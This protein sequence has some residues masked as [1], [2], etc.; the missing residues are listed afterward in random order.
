MFFVLWFL[1]RNHGSKLWGL[2]YVFNLKNERIVII[3]KNTRICVSFAFWIMMGL[4]FIKWLWNGMCACILALNSMWSIFKLAFEH[5]FYFLMGS[6]LGYCNGNIE[7]LSIFGMNWD[8]LC[9][10]EKCSNL[11]LSLIWEDWRDI[12]I[13]G[14]SIFEHKSISIFE[15][16]LGL[17]VCECLRGV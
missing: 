7:N 14:T 15:G 5:A 8:Y 17:R 2:H 6:M 9:L 10:W 13:W 4:V 12:Y 16:S 11:G 1:H 3:G